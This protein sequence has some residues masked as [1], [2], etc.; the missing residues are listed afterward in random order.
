MVKFKRGA[1]KNYECIVYVASSLEAYISAGINFVRALELINTGLNNNAYKSSIQRVAKR[2]NE[3]ESIASAFLAEEDLYTSVFA[4]MLF[5]AEQSGQIEMVLRNMTVHFEKELKLKGE[6]RQALMYPKFIF[7]AMFIVF[8]LFLDIVL[9]N[10]VSMYESLDVKMSGVTTFLIA[11]NSFF[12]KHNIYLVTVTFLVV[13]FMCMLFIKKSLKGKDIFAKFTIRK[14]YKELTLI[15]ILKLI[16]ESGIPVVYA[17]ERLSHSIAENYM[18]DYINMILESVR[19]GN[20]IYYAIE[21]ID[22]ISEVSKSFILSGE[23]SGKLDSTMKKLLNI[24]EG[25]FSKKLKAYVSKIEPISICFLGG[26]VLMLMLAVFVPMYEYMH[27][28]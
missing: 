12:E 28:V 7:I 16:L 19:N 25:N 18:R 21:Q 3:G 15:G 27:Y 11:V 8:I 9:P 4:D 5:V 20:D 23:N 1:R 17:L 24:L 13:I 26:M 10:I 22:V 6:V 14:R 2:L